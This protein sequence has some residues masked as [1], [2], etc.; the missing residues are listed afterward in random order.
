MKIETI[1]LVLLAATNPVR[2]TE[3]SDAR[4]QSLA[5]RRTPDVHS[6]TMLVIVKHESIG[7]PY[8]I[9][10]NKRTGKNPSPRSQS[11]ASTVATR[12]VFSGQNNDMGLGQINSSHLTNLGLSVESLFD[13]CTNL[14][15]ASS[16]LV[17]NYVRETNG[18]C[19]E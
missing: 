6:Q 19:N 2:A 1:L 17:D 9:N 10:V 14:R 11:E 13:P 18:S 8:A 3:L 15:V 7:N 16:V 12:L 5:I 4:L